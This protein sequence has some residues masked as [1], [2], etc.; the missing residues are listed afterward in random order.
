MSDDALSP[1]QFARQAGLTLQYVYSLLAAGRL[2][3]ERREGRWQI[4]AAELE[5]RQRREVV[6]A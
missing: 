3:A 1:A 4:A 2:E 5:K 6:G